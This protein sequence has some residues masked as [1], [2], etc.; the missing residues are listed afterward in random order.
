M[1]VQRQITNAPYS[2]CD[3]RS[4]AHKRNV[5]L[6]LRRLSQAHCF[7]SFRR[8][9]KSDSVDDRA[10]AQPSTSSDT[11]YSPRVGGD[12]GKIDS[13]HGELSNP[14]LNR[15]SA[16]DRTEGHVT[17]QQGPFL[18][19]TASDTDHHRIA[20]WPIEMDDGDVKLDSLLQRNNGGNDT[21]PKA[22]SPRS[23]QRRP[24]QA[25]FVT[26]L[27]E[28]TPTVNISSKDD[29]SPIKS[30]T[31][32][33]KSNPDFRPL[34]S[35]G[36]VG[37]VKPGTFPV[38]GKGER[39]RRSS[40]SIKKMTAIK[41]EL[42]GD[43]RNPSGVG[44]DFAS[45]N[46]GDGSHGLR[47]AAAE[48]TPTAVHSRCNM[49]VDNS[50]SRSEG[51]ASVSSLETSTGKVATSSRISESCRISSTK[52]STPKLAPPN[53]VDGHEYST[54]TVVDKNASPRSSRVDNLQLATGHAA[55]AAHA[56]SQEDGSSIISA[57]IASSVPRPGA[58]TSYSRPQGYR[59]HPPPMGGDCSSQQTGQDHQEQPGPSSSVA[60]NRSEEDPD[61]GESAR[62]LGEADIRTTTTAAT[63]PATN[64]T[65]DSRVS[66][67]FKTKKCMIAALVLVTVA[68]VVVLA[69]VLGR[70]PPPAAASTALP[71]NDVTASPSMGPSEL[72]PIKVE[73]TEL[74]IF[75][76]IS[77]SDDLQTPDSPQNQAWLWLLS[78]DQNISLSNNMTQNGVQKL[79][80]RYILAVFYFALGGNEWTSSHD[81]LSGVSDECDWEFITCNDTSGEVLHIQT[82]NIIGGN[83]P[84]E[85]SNNMVGG[86][87]SELT[88]LLSLGKASLDS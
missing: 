19:G 20:S 34:S 66:V 77:S 49:G 80:A 62:Q 74:Y 12:E 81:W 15:S 47:L 88:H 45:S 3:T 28:P 56:T 70:V 5:Y 75:D 44:I 16:C 33:T 46:R 83:D 25:S 59:S 72:D 8:E 52:G 64:K 68:I 13:D 18:T 23:V 71:I 22:S 76:Q 38:S 60:S 53:H 32:P 86:L 14:K 65:N 78:R 85:G 48:E 50:K 63:E 55:V 41:S 61:P 1:V 42:N 29:R 79:R 69:L 51:I 7:L 30:C 67:F 37:S 36:P 26:T 31:T 27:S 73:A 4:R 24:F 43:G 10:V 54:G 6:K 57:K 39:G 35:S 17:Y 82:T 87:P 9:M 21:P 40:G 2:Y 11:H 58:R 84:L